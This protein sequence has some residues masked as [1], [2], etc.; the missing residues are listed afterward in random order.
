VPTRRLFARLTVRRISG[1]LGRSPCGRVIMTH[2]GSGMT[3]A[4]A[5]SK[6]TAHPGI[7]DEAGGWGFH[8]DVHPEAPRVEP[9]LRASEAQLGKGRRSDDRQRAEVDER[10]RRRGAL[11]ADF[12]EEGRLPLRVGAGHRTDKC[13]APTEVR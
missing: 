1:S 10:I 2:R 5:E 12:G 3:I 6:L 13:D 11:Q 4:S 7:L 9:A 8:D